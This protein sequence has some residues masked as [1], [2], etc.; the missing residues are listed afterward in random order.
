MQENNLKGIWIP[1]KV[2]TNKKYLKEII[3]NCKTIIIDKSI[4]EEY[5]NEEYNEINGLVYDWF[6]I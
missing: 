6:S 4:I 3:I 2:L 1:Y 5:L